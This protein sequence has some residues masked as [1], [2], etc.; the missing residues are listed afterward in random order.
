MRV[1]LQRVSRASV[2]IANE[3]AG[4]IAGGLCLLIG[5]AHG[6][7]EAEA[8][9][10]ADKIAGLRVFADSDGRMNLSL[11][12]SGG[13][14]LVISQ[15]T[16]Y[17]DATKGRRPSFVDAARPEVAI[18]LYE[19]FIDALQRRGLTVATGEFGASMQVEIHND[20][21]VTLILERAPA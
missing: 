16:L 15:F 9:W 11:A 10:M 1:I 4:R 14:V 5:F 19:G 18:P 21:P 13:S 12:E 17:G 2:T 8:E 7:T 20:G 6:D 3:V